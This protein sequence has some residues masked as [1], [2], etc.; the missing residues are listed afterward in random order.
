M[1]YVSTL[2]DL[3]SGKRVS[4]EYAALNPFAEDGG[5]WVPDE[6]PV[7]PLDTLKS[8]AG[9][10]YQEIMFNVMSLYI[11]ESELPAEDLRK[12]IDA[13]LDG[14]FHDDIA[15][16]V[17]VGDRHV[18]ELFHGHTLAFKDYAMRLTVNLV[19]HFV[20]RKKENRSRVNVV[21][22]TSGDTGPSA[23]RAAMLNNDVMNFW[24]LYPV[25]KVSRQQ[26][27]QMTTTN[28]P[29]VHII[30][31]NG[32]D[33]DGLDTVIDDMMSDTEFVRDMKLLSVNSVN[34]GRIVAQSVHFIFSYLRLVPECNK[35]IVYSIPC[36]ACG[37][38]LGGYIA[39]TMGLPVKEFVVANNKNASIVPLFQT[40]K[41]VRNTT[42]ATYSNAIDIQVPYNIYRLLYYTAAERDAKK[43]K[44]WMD[45]L[46]S[47]KGTM[48]L[49]ES[50]LKL[51]QKGYVSMAISEEETLATMSSFFNSKS[52]PPYVLDPHTAVAMAASLHYYPEN[53]R[54]KSIPIVVVSTAHPSKFPDVCKKVTGESCPTLDHHSLLKM[55]FERESFYRVTG[56]DE[57]LTLLK[58]NMPLFSK[59]L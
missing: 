12:I 2:S 39:V 21:V 38:L 46:A 52:S 33:S 55:K 56:H 24:C 36:G 23:A 34:I 31:V 29:N 22:A 35:Q 30:A 6:I 41:M 51:V 16:S 14:F 58:H 4:F 13:S 9:K 26:E 40:G 53:E 54:D 10:S 57:A 7:I 18:L 3:A 27:Q 50:E 28:A 5:L 47:E 49:T 32:L 8:W 15:P 48:Q 42:S 59:S 25:G 20:R 44:S 17:P 37:N 19:C 11:S 45:S 1:K 43:L